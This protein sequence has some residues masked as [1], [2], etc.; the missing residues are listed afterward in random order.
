M[1]RISLLAVIAACSV[2][3]TSRAQADIY[4]CTDDEGNVAY[5]QLPCPVEVEKPAEPVA[6]TDDAELEQHIEPEYAEPT[7]PASSRQ[8]GEL[9]EACKK[10]YRDQID[11]VEAE[12]FAANLAEQGEA[13]KERL[14]ALAQQLRACG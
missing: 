1:I 11:A 7:P 8:P 2:A 13:Y 4:K 5:L 9:P 14:L 12:L 10:R 6:Q 3:T